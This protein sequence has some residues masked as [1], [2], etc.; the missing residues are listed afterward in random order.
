MEYP[1]K[2]SKIVAKFAK[3][4]TVTASKDFEIPVVRAGA[5][6]LVVLVVL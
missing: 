2:S 5:V 1:A 6:E 3:K 4:E